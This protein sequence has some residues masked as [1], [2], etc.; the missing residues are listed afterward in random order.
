MSRWAF[1]LLKVGK[2]DGNNTAVYVFTESFFYW[3]NCEL[4]FAEFV[5]IQNFEARSPFVVVKNCIGKTSDLK[6]EV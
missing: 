6:F 3:D 4:G 2:C 1:K 5:D